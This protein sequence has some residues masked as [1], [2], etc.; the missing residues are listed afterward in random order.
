MIIYLKL[1]SRYFAA[2]LILRF[3]RYCSL[4]N[5]IRNFASRIFLSSGTISSKFQSF[6]WNFGGFLDQGKF[7]LG[8][9]LC[10]FRHVVVVVALNLISNFGYLPLVF[11]ISGQNFFKF[12]QLS[13]YSSHAT[14]SK[15]CR[16]VGP[17]NNSKYSCK[18]VA[19]SSAMLLLCAS[20]HFL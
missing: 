6:S 13:Q 10:R 12:D 17:A 5:R 3:L 9:V 8:E 19:W 14:D 20:S 15:C 18:F 1:F 7:W 16:A 4:L 11:Q 2:I